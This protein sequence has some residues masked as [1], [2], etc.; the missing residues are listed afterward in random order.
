MKAYLSLLLALCALAG[1]ACRQAVPNA[2]DI[3]MQSSN[4]DSVHAIIDTASTDESGSFSFLSFDEPPVLLQSTPAVY[5]PNSR[6][7]GIQGNVI[8]NVEVLPDGTVGEMSVRGSLQRG[9]GALDE[10]AMATVKQWKYQ[11][12]LKDTTPVAAKIVQIVEFKL[13]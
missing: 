3:N 13:N 11:P 7:T 10:V 12:A 5:P 8:L 1:V 4:A 2:E 9:K 6:K